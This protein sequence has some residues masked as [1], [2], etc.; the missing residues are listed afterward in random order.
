VRGVDPRGRR[1]AQVQAAALARLAEDRPRVGDVLIERAGPLDPALRLLRLAPGA[2][3]AGD[4]AEQG[5]QSIVD[6]V[7]LARR[8]A[9]AQR[10]PDQQ[11][12]QQADDDPD[13]RVEQPR[14]R[15]TPR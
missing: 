10:R 9:I 3:V 8:R 14:P 5:A 1:A 12:D 2:H 13:Q 4:V 6:D 7:D 15:A 11:V